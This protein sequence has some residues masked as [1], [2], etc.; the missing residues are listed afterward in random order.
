ML[1]HKKR[2]LRKVKLNNN[3]GATV[4]WSDTYFNPESGTYITNTE[5]RTSDA[6]VH[7]D[8][9]AAMAP[10]KEHLAIACEEVPEPKANHP[11]DGSLKGID[12][13]YASSVSFS[14]GIVKEE[15]EDSPPIGVHI[16]GRKTL[17]GGR[18]VNFGTPGLKL[19]A[20][21]E[22][23]KFI[24]ALDVHVQALEAEVWAYLD[25]KHAPIHQTTM[26]FNDADGVDGEPAKETADVLGSAQ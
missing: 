23:Y 2:L 26:N 12:K 18:V 7:E 14:G 1:Q 4:E 9:M 3:G 22:P 25:G 10:I 8:L 5:A 19:G 16:F 11:F 20:P 15:G 17:K 13:F 24:T 6:P 21:Q